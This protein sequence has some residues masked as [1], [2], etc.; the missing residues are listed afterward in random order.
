MQVVVG[1]VGRAHGVCGELAVDV[2]TDEPGRRFVPGAV[3][4]VESSDRRPPADAYPSLTVVGV[5]EH[6]PRLLV[7]FDEVADRDAA[8]TLRGA[9]LSA[10]V[11]DDERPEDP[12]E[13]YDHQL[14]GLRARTTQ[15]D[16]LGNVREVLHLPA[17]DVLRIG[18]EHGAEVLVPFVSPLVPTV[19]PEDGLLVVADVPGLLDPD[20]AEQ[21]EQ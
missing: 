3:L 17:Q 14:V 13:F 4:Y 16:V 8:E 21:V 11:D 1:R 19:R 5:R 7:T 9:T 2:R 15:G 18:D 20:A 10:E 6:G 12:E